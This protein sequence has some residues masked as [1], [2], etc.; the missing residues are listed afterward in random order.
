MSFQSAHVCDSN[1]LGTSDIDNVANERNFNNTCKFKSNCTNLDKCL[2]PHHFSIISPINMTFN[3][4]KEVITKTACNLGKSK[5]QLDEN[6][7][8]NNIYGHQKTKGLKI[9]FQNIQH[10]LPKLDEIKY[11]FTKMKDWEKPHVLG[12]CETFITP[13]KCHD[14][15][16]ELET[17]GFTFE[18]KDR[19]TSKG[20]GW[21]I[22]FSDEIKYTRRWEFES[23][24]IESMWFEIFS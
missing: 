9:T 2:S 7:Y 14:K 1:L 10:L 22:Y 24:N 16:K 15:S 3:N 6:D 21:I 11:N 4:T 17:S 20:G 8:T 12:M 18:R 23:D 19:K 5:T 13:E